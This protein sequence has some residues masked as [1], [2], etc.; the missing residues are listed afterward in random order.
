MNYFEGKEIYKWII[1]L[2]FIQL[3]E[4]FRFAVY[5]RRRNMEAEVPVLCEFNAVTFYVLKWRTEVL[6]GQL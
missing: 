6:G 5:Q 3:N 1:V 2:L 4:G